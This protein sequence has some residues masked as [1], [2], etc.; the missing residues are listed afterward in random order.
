MFRRSLLPQRRLP[1]IGHPGLQQLR[2]WSCFGLRFLS[3]RSA[4]ARPEFFGLEE[5]VRCGRCPEEVRLQA[6]R[7]Y[8]PQNSKRPGVGSARPLLGGIWP[9]TL[10]VLARPDQPRET[11]TVGVAHRGFGLGIPTYGRTQHPFRQE[12][13][14]SLCWRVTFP[15]GILYGRS[16]DHEY[17]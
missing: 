14:N 1:E 2:A 17:V 12:T 16:P 3:C 6:I 13:E 11:G 7:R 9:N 15:P 5:V 8:P 4:C 10:E